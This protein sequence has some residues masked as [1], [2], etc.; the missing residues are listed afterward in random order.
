MPCQRCKGTASFRNFA[1]R[2]SESCNR[3]A[4]ATSRIKS[5][6]ATSD[7]TFSLMDFI[8]ESNKARRSF[9][10]FGSGTGGSGGNCC[11]V[12][13]SMT[14]HRRA[15][16]YVADQG[17]AFPL[18]K[19]W[20]LRAPIAGC[21]TRPRCRPRVV[22]FRASYV[23]CMSRSTLEPSETPTYAPAHWPWERIALLSLY[24]GMASLPF[25]E[26]FILRCRVS[27]HARLRGGGTLLI[28]VLPFLMLVLYACTSRFMCD[29][30]SVILCRVVRI[31][32]FWTS[33]KKAGE[34][35]EDAPILVIPLLLACQ[36]YIQY[37]DASFVPRRDAHTA[38]GS[39]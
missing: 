15:P 20:P 2:G 25:V 39:K 23:V 18:G 6:A 29:D 3:P 7:W 27:G 31:A 21:E 19:G 5:A 34:E 33:N 28:Y 38:T 26:W 13:I 32:T 12:I 4:L 14:F 16:S 37:S 22:K 1:E 11:A 36:A 35:M 24:C 9:G 10:E 8:S 30:S 17:A